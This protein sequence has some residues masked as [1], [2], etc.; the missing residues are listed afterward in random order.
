[1]D[2][3]LKLSSRPEGDHITHF[4]NYKE[5]FISKWYNWRGTYDVNVIYNGWK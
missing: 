2:G 1:L 5:M 4:F 3:V